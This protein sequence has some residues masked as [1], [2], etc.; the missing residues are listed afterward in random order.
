MTLRNENPNRLRS[1][2]WDTGPYF[3]LVKPE[4]PALAEG[5]DPDSVEHRVALEEYEAS[6]RRWRAAKQQFERE[7]AEWEKTSGGGAVELDMFHVDAGE[8]LEKDP[9]RY[10]AA[11]PHG[12]KAGLKADAARKVM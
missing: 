2:I 9:R 6:Y 5:Q 10:H 4:A 12:A 1:R 3:A 7:R 8:S 11:L